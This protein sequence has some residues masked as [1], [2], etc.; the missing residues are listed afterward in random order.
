[1]LECPP[2]PALLF[3]LWLPTLAGLTCLAPRALRGCARD[4]PEPASR[5]TGCHTR[6]TSPA[7][8]RLTCPPSDPP[9]VHPPTRPGADTYVN[10]SVAVDDNNSAKIIYRCNP[11]SK[12]D[13]KN[14]IV[15]WVYRKVGAGGR[16]CLLFGCVFFGGRWLCAALSVPRPPT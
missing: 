13:H 3:V 11:G 6:L 5:T 15:G 16:G 10:C 9:S 2:S 4:A 1:M 7:R 14:A 12:L 8:P